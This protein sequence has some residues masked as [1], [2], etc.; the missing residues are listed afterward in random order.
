M[1]ERER[2]GEGR[3]PTAL[4]FLNDDVGK[5]LPRKMS[6]QE[7]ALGRF[8]V[9]DRFRSLSRL[10]EFVESRREAVREQHEP[11]VDVVI[12]MLGS[13]QK[14]SGIVLA[15]KIRKRCRKAFVV[16]FSRTA[17]ESAGVRMRCFDAG[18]NMVTFDPRA[19]QEALEQIHHH[20]LARL[21]LRTAL[22]SPPGGGG[23]G[24]EAAPRARGFACPNCR[25]RG[26]PEDVLWAHGPLY[27]CNE[28]SVTGVACPVCK[29]IVHG[30]LWVHLHNKHGPIGRGERHS[31]DAVTERPPIYSFALV[32]CRN[33]RDGR[34]LVVQEFCNKGFWLPG[35]GVDS[36]EDLCTAAVRETLEEAGV[37]VE[38]KGVLRVE[39]TPRE[40]H[41]RL[42]VI[43]YAEPVAATTPKSLPDYES[44]GASWIRADEL[45]GVRLR[46]REPVDWIHY[47][48]NGGL[49]FP[50]A[51][52]SGERSPVCVLSEPF[53]VVEPNKEPEE[54]EM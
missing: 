22:P 39:H 53:R 34:Y 42:R 11:I 8:D 31:A 19:L 48:E 28:P 24:I 9:L 15:K 37:Q 16:I 47:L 41:V 40:S 54:V 7:S 6:L 18:C 25:M 35:G 33:P 13:S 36:G 12:S 23:G 32:V 51:L 30:P 50:L 10:E 44:V 45:R 21:S 1:E 38:L 52:I 14:N 26:L 27:H 5:L 20:F 3:R 2:E 46:G 17:A 29:S 4:L 43:F 49:V